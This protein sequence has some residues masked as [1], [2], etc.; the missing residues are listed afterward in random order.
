[1]GPRKI[2]GIILV[3]IGLGVIYTGYEM[4]GS[5]G[6]QLGSALSGSPSDSV[7]LRYVVGAVCVLGGGFLAK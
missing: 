2:G 7:M 1:M 6:N 4:S 3:I 5:I